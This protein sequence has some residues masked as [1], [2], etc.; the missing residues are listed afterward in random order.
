MANYTED[1]KN[2]TER[3]WRHTPEAWTTSPGAHT[4]EEWLEQGVD[5]FKLE[6]AFQGGR[7][8]TETIRWL[9]EKKYIVK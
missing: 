5:F 1:P 6:R 4:A 8:E 2:L 7:D 9:S 3:S